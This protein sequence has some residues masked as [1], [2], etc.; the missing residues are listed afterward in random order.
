MKRVINSASSPSWKFNNYIREL[1][2]FITDAGQKRTEY[3][4]YKKPADF[5]ASINL[6]DLAF[7]RLH[8]FGRY[9]NELIV[10]GEL[11]YD[12]QDYFLDMYDT[13]YDEINDSYDAL[14]EL[15]NEAKQRKSESSNGAKRRRLTGSEQYAVEIAARLID[16]GYSIE[17]AA[18]KACDEVSYGNAE[19]EY[20]GED[21]YED[22]PDVSKVIEYLLARERGEVR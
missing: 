20:E 17:D 14:R 3:I 19:P 12:G 13:F 18:Y 16:E 6:T 7:R 5:K 4:K 1:D 2:K 15:Q 9:A 11:S 22:E 21:F 8:E 10:N